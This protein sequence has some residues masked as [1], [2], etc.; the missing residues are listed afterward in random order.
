M[1]A[2]V[3]Q[4]GCNVALKRKSR[5]GNFE[6]DTSYQLQGVA[7]TT[8]TTTTARRRSQRSGGG[9]GDGGQT[10]KERAS[11]A[12][13][14]FADNPLYDASTAPHSTGNTND[15]NDSDDEIYSNETPVPNAN[16]AQVCGN[17]I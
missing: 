9:G 12:G 15:T 6:L 1:Y 5:S 8:T 10:A 4:A 13:I 11:A 16:T 3:F 14:M 17:Y 2:R 7:S